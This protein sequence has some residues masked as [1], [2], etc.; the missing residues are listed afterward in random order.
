MKFFHRLSFEPIGVQSSK[1]DEVEKT[2]K[3]IQERL[4]SY[5]SSEEAAVENRIR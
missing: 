4:N 3:S 2:L 1:Y 5:I